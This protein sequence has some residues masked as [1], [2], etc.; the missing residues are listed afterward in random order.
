M[1]FTLNRSVLF[2]PQQIWFWVHWLLCLPVNTGSWVSGGAT[3][4]WPFTWMWGYISQAQ[5]FPCLLV[6]LKDLVPG[7]CVSP[8]FRAFGPCSCMT[9]HRTAFANLIWSSLNSRDARNWRPLGPTSLPHSWKLCHHL[10][11]LAFIGMFFGDSLTTSLESNLA[12]LFLRSDSQESN[13]ESFFFCLFSLSKCTVCLLQC[14]VQMEK[15]TSSCSTHAGSPL[16]FN[17]SNHELA[18]FPLPLF[19]DFSGDSLTNLVQI[20][21]ILFFIIDC[22]HQ[23]T[24]C[25]SW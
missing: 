20:W 12:S 6:F 2:Q 8:R 9:R 11:L 16:L 22:P 18:I 1:Y 7:N 13:K 21:S 3:C 23:S 15:P 4:L 24:T 5:A 14:V 25:V 10:Y 19:H 17:Y